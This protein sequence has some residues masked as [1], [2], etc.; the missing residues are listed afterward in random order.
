MPGWPGRGGAAVKGHL[1]FLHHCSDMMP[2]G[3][4]L[5]GTSGRGKAAH[6]YMAYCHSAC[7]VGRPYAD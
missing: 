4:R 7:F 1:V 3:L 5:I 2:W 6:Y